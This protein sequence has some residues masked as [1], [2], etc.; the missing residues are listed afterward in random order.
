MMDDVEHLFCYVLQIFIKFI[1]EILLIIKAW[2][3]FDLYPILKR[4][5]HEIYELVARFARRCHK[6][7]IEN[8]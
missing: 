3:R 1:F 7:T 4:R 5:E 8:L 2:S 6:R